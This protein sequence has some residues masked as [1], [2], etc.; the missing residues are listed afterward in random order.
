[1]S[2]QFS[3]ER[4]VRRLILLGGLLASAGPA[5]AAPQAILPFAA[6]TW[7]ELLHSPLRPMAVVFT[8]TDCVHCPGAI[9]SLAAAIRKSGSRVRLAVVVMDGAGQEDA[10][11]KDRHYRWANALYAFDGDTTALRFKVNPDWRG[12]TPYVALIPAAGAAGFHTGSPPAPALRTFLR[13]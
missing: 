13:P 8:T 7:R 1:M 2:C 9:D 11:R 5:F 12:L 4:R 3:L 10:L 6:D